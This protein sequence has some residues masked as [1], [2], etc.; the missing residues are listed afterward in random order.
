[1][2]PPSISKNRGIP[3]HLEKY[4]KPDQLDEVLPETDVV[5]V[6]APHTEQSHHMM[7]KKEFELMKQAR[8]LW[9]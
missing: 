1:M 3:S 8:I 5:F 9:P 7:G 6:S 4:V 2:P